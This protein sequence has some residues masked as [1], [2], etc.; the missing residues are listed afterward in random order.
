MPEQAVNILDI[1][2]RTQDAVASTMDVA[3]AEKK[4]AV[5]AETIL[6][7]AEQAQ[8]AAGRDQAIVVGQQLV[9]QMQAQQRA[10]KAVDAAGGYDAL[11][12]LINRMSETGAVLEKDVQQLAKEKNTRLIDDPLEWL[13]AQ[14]DWNGTETKVASGVQV[15]QTQQ[16]VAGA[17]EGRINQVGQISKATAETITAASI[18][19][20]TDEIAQQSTIQAAKTRL[21]GL[22]WN[23]QG[24]RA[25]AEA[26][27]KTV[28]FMMQAGNFERG[29]QQL[30][31][32]LREEDRRQAQFDWQKEQK[33]DQ[34]G[35][36][37]RLVYFVNL[38]EKAR[39]QQPTSA[40]EIKDA[41]K[42]K[43]GLADEYA[44]LYKNGKL[45]ANGAPPMIGTSSAQTAA[46]LLK[47]PR[48]LQQLPEERKK[49]GELILAVTKML[50]EELAKPGS[51]LADDKTGVK[52]SRYI[53]DEV[54]A[55]LKR[56][57]AYV[58][59]NPDN[60]FYLGDLSSYVNTA[61]SPDVS[62]YQRYP[63]FQ[64]V[65]GPAIEKNISM[66]DPNTVFGLA[67]SAV[68][69]GDI[70]SAQASGD[71]ANIYKR[72]VALHL[73]TVGFNGFGITLPKEAAGY[74]VKIG[75]DVVDVTNFVEVASAMN[76]QLA[77]QRERGMQ[78]RQPG[79]SL[80][81]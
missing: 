67:F 49:A 32:A 3:V 14:F 10:Q 1:I 37:E 78:A 18:E 40:Q 74:R 43:G 59:N 56:Q 4:N 51:A 11:Y 5:K 41:I 81:R 6:A 33:D 17:I 64:K 12:G 45:I 80:P 61:A 19:A 73:A 20:Q 22:K 55:Q 57:A 36:D 76:R 26:D 63:L 47:D 77:T 23:S 71:I 15:L 28:G 65:I 16:A 70:S 75:K 72:T 2:R 29:Q 44:E 69:R 38:G 62:A 79:M 9:G 54:T 13:K 21:E 30:E 46:A 53:N 27:E 50:G 58:G 48:I 35:F 24:V 60:I 68:S 8:V 7:E 34:K 25:I 42:L 66:S 52:Q 39:G 31:L